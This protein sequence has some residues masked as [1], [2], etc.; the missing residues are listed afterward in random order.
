MVRLIVVSG[1]SSVTKKKKKKWKKEKEK[2]K[3]K[4]NLIL[5]DWKPFLYITRNTKQYEATQH[6]TKLQSSSWDLPLLLA[7]SLDTNMKTKASSPRQ[8]LNSTT[9]SS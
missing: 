1:F 5:V 4:E 8:T 9:Y 3:E 7:S 6:N 2:E